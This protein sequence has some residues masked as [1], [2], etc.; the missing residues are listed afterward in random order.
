MYEPVDLAGLGASLAINTHRTLETLEIN[1]RVGD[2]YDPLCG[3]NSELRFIAGNNILEGLGL[4]VAI[5][6]SYSY[7]DDTEDWSVF[8]SVLTESGAFPRLHRVWLGIS[9]HSGRDLIEQ[10][11]MLEI[12]TEDKFPRLVESKEIQF[13]FRAEIQYDNDSEQME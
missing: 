2:D 5:P 8:D 11:A 9:W 6:N 10:D 3:L 1:I 12:L 4:D 7:P 13:N